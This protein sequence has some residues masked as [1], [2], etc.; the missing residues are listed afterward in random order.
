MYYSP[1]TVCQNSAWKKILFNATA[2]R[3][4]SLPL[5]GWSSFVLK[6]DENIQRMCQN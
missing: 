6:A 2:Q 5:E 3:S 1:I 4:I